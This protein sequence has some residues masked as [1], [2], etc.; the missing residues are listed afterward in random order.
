MYRIL[1]ILLRT[2]YNFPTTLNW[3]FVYFLAYFQSNWVVHVFLHVYKHKV[4]T[5]VLH[6]LVNTWHKF[7]AALHWR[8]V[9]W[10]VYW[11]WVRFLTAPN[12][13]CYIICEYVYWQTSCNYIFFATNECCVILHTYSFPIKL[14][15]P[16]L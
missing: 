13:F 6:I 16:S 10:F 15:I 2:E 12:N 5:C 3:C 9:Q 1:H 14:E 4:Y 11:S 8:F 7:L